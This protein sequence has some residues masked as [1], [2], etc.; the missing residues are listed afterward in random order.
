MDV[1]FEFFSIEPSTIIGV[2]CNTL[3]L[4]LIFKKYLFG[5]IN[6][7]IEERKAQVSQTYNEADNALK[8]AKDLESQYSQKLE[9]AREE[10]AE[11]VKA[12]S[13]KAQLRSDE[14]ILEAKSEAADIISKANSEIMRERRLAVSEMKSQV[15]DIAADIAGKIIGR[16]VS[17][18]EEQERLIDEFIAELDENDK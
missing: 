8:N 16:E 4:F 12:A 11:I 1:N 14:I 13:Q 17:S 3:I 2:L 18:D 5:P 10:S 15:S 7:I 9:T 6:R